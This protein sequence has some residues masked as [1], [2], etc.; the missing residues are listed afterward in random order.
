MPFLTTPAGI[1]LLIFLMNLPFGY[2]RAGVRKLS[3][4][5][6]VAIHLPVLLAILMR[7]AMGVPFRWITLPLY[8]A[9][10]FF[11]QLAGARWRRQQHSA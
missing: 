10:F 5:W 6:F 7:V 11:G 9:A 4:A 8:V 2:W 1:A 3:P